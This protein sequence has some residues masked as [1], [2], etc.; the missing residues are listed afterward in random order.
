MKEKLWKVFWISFTLATIFWFTGMNIAVGNQAEFLSFLSEAA[1][2]MGIL[3][4]GIFC[5]FM[6]FQSIGIFC[7]YHVGRG[8]SLICLALAIIGYLQ[9]NIILWQVEIA[10]GTLL[11]Y[12]SWDGR[13]LIELLLYGILIGLVWRFSQFFYTNTVKICFILI[14]VQIIGFLP[15]YMAGSESLFY[16]NY[17]TI[18]ENQLLRECKYATFVN[19]NGKYHFSNKSNVIIVI[20]DTLGEN[21]FEGACKNSGGKLQ[22]AFCDF[23]H[24]S[25]LISPNPWTYTAVPMLMTGSDIFE[26]KLATNDSYFVK[27]EKAYHEKW[28]LF[29]QCSKAG[30]R[31]DV[32]TFFNLP[33]PV[34]K[35][36]IANI[37]SI[38][39]S[40]CQLSMLFQDRLIPLTFYRLSPLLLKKPVYLLAQQYGWTT[41]LAIQKYL[42]KTPGITTIW[43]TGDMIGFSDLEQ[44]KIQEQQEKI[45][46][47]TDSF[48]W[49]LKPNFQIDAQKQFFVFHLQSVHVHGI[50]KSSYDREHYVQLARHDLE[51]TVRFLEML[52][53]RNIY[54]NS[55]IVLCGDH[56]SYREPE[57]HKNP[58]MLIKKPQQRHNVMA[59]NDTPILLRDIAPTILS[60]LEIVTQNTYSI[61]NLSPEQKK[62]RDVYWENRISKEPHLQ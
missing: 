7:G 49:N 36:W 14:V 3:A 27:K 31:C 45:R 1:L 18:P 16:S 59:E 48:F 46:I 34:H 44:S 55:Y 8:S 29:E 50:D 47:N 15:N 32:V 54:D 42:M 53:E 9:A 21:Y 62:E 30:Y 11:G 33:Y 4:S 60:D 52:K 61:W 19:E 23:T 13:V 37:E 17:E 56:G 24:F 25:R 10:G 22:Q 39:S 28:N 2:G 6:L 5:F 35:G 43:A 57:F 38:R 51:R 41:Y 20:L 12:N 40:H 26:D 58:F